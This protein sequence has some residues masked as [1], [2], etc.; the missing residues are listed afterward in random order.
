[1]KRLAAIWFTLISAFLTV[2]SVEQPSNPA[3]RT[4]QPETR[5]IGVFDSGTGGLTVLEKMLGEDFAGESFVYLGD[6]ANMPYGDYAAAGKSDFLRGLVVNDAKFLL[7]KDAKIIVIA[8][9][10]ATAWGYDA[11]AKM[12][13][14]R[15]GGVKVVGVV[16]AGARAAIEALGLGGAAPGLGSGV[17]GLGSGNSTPATRNPKPETRPTEPCAIGVMA[18]PGTIASGVYERTIKAELEKAGSKAEVRVFSRGCE[19]LADAVERGSADA[20]A[21]AVANLKALLGECAQKAPGLKMKAVI[22]GC[23]HFPFLLA[24]LEKAAPEGMLFIDPAEN[25]AKE[26]LSVLKSSD[27]LAPAGAEGKVEVYVSVPAK[28]IDP[29][30]LD[31]KGGLRREWKYGRDDPDAD[32]STEIVSIAEA[33]GGDPLSFVPFAHMVPRVRE[34]LVRLAAEGG[35]VLAKLA[36]HL[37]AVAAHAA[38]WGLLLVFVF[39]AVESSFIPFPSEV[40]MIPAGF[41]CARGEMQSLYLAILA[42]ILGS[43]A[44]AFVNY[45]LALFVGRPFLERYGR[46]FFIKRESLDRACDVFNRYGAAT[47]FLCRMVPVVRQ[48]ISIPAGIAR[49]PLGAFTLFTALGAGI[50]TA[51]LAF[52]GY[53]IGRSVSDM[54]YLE[55]CMRGK[56][57]VGKHTP[58]VIVSGI[59]LVAAYMLVK[60]LVIGKARAPSA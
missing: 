33:T 13:E 29:K 6:Q 1:M 21:I 51:V 39:M 14:K 52:A 56:E 43:L 50:W 19:G 59:A 37:D 10:T 25:A 5:P 34:R 15:G 46:W 30:L 3:T 24:D 41:L 23:T 54:S 40:V 18:T 38:T 9:N 57:L 2:A 55:L 42:G 31:E 32:R 7:S 28:G 26:C 35:G 58:L 17:S 16:S 53:S 27:A 4:P 36:A 47:T 22:L 20:P 11:V 8:C 48:L 12:L 44:G 49:M 60:K 45:Y